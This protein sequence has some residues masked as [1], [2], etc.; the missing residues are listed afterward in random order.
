MGLSPRV[1]LRGSIPA[2]AGEPRF[3]P[4]SRWL[5]KVYPLLP[6]YMVRPVWIEAS[7][8]D[9]PASVSDL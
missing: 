2:R 4:I 7:A 1:P 9:M 3:W 6:S 5:I 8:A